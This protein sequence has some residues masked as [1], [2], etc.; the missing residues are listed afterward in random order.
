M[1]EPETCLSQAGL[2]VALPGTHDHSH[3]HT[4]HESPA[5]EASGSTSKPKQRAVGHPSPTRTRSTRSTRSLR[6]ASSRT[7]S[8]TDLKT[9]PP[10]SSPKV[11]EFSCPI[12]CLDYEPAEVASS[13]F[14]LSCGHRACTDC[15]TTYLESKIRDEGE[16]VRIGCMESGCGKIVGEKIV[17]GLVGEETKER[18]GALLNRTYVDDN[19]VL[20]WCPGPE[21]AFSPSFFRNL[22]LCIS[23][24]RL[25]ARFH[26]PSTGEFAIEC[27]QAPA[28]QLNTIIPTVH[29]HCGQTFCFGCTEPGDHRPVICKIAKL[30][31]KKCADDSETSNWISAN[32]KECTKCQSTI[33]KNGGCK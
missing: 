31:K 18:Y 24:D 29:C 12:C 6:S 32:T 5:P 7:P 27:K 10:A 17:D 25:R 20:R 2:D 9:P 15:W 21:C 26:I 13:T 23:A 33:E 11:E 22:L 30:W 16:S 14:A 19:P 3:G 4:H 8:P 28:K 1:E